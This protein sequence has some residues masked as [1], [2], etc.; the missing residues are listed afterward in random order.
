MFP[1][2]KINLRQ[3]GKWWAVR[4]EIDDLT[5]ADPTLQETYNL[6]MRGRMPRLRGLACSVLVVL[7]AV[8]DPIRDE[9]N[10]GGIQRRP[11]G[12]HSPR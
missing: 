1:A 10:L 7:G 4:E 11:T 12:R 3:R 2:R 8:V 6:S 5:I 9:L